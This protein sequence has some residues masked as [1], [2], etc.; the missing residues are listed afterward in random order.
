MMIQFAAY[1]PIARIMIRYG[2]GAVIGADMADVLAGDP[3]VITVAAA[4]IGAGVEAVYA[5]AKRRGWAT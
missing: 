2:A 4:A 3:D 5:L 1:A